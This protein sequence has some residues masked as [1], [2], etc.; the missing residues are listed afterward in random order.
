MI[1]YIDREI[2][3]VLLPKKATI[4]NFLNKAKVAKETYFC[5]IL[6]NIYIALTSSTVDLVEEYKQYYCE[7]P[8]L[9]TFIYKKYPSIDDEELLEIF[10]K[11]QTGKYHLL[12]GN[13]SAY[14]D[15]NL[16]SLFSDEEF[17]QK[18]QKLLEAE[19]YEN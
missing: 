4:D 13:M 18:I 3:I 5:S 2:H 10:E 7:Y 16:N 8:N 9:K 14:Y 6:E 1:I 17:M 19:T 12:K 15:Y 11:M